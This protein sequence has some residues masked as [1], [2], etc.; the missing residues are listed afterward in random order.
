MR[1]TQLVK[2][3][4]LLFF[5]VKSHMVLVKAPCDWRCTFSS[6]PFSVSQ[7]IYPLPHSAF[8]LSRPPHVSFSPTFWTFLSLSSPFALIPSHTLSHTLWL[9]FQTNFIPKQLH[10]TNH[11]PTFWRIW[12]S[13]FCWSCS[14]KTDF[15]F[16]IDIKCIQI[17]RFRCCQHKCIFFWPIWSHKGIFYTFSEGG[18]SK[19]H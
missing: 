12:S 14:R 4:L 2:S 18:R 10:N 5:L 13:S 15:F 17:F 3:W 7:P 6:S 19:M 11:S 9:S 1:R 16:L 8:Q